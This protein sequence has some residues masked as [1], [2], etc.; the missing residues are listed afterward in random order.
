MALGLDIRWDP[1]DAPGIDDAAEAATW[2]KLRIAAPANG[3]SESVLTQVYAVHERS[4][5][6]EVFGTVLPLAEWVVRSWSHII[7]ARRADPGSL[8]PADDRY[9]WDRVHRWRYAGEGVAVP[10]LCISRLDDDLANVTWAADSD[11]PETRFERIRFLTRGALRLSVEDLRT[12]LADFVDSVIRR[13]LATAPDHDRT[14]EVRN[15]WNLVRRPDAP[16][17]G[18]QALAARLGLLW[19]DLAEEEQNRIQLLAGRPLD[20]V[21]LELLNSVRLGE[22]G[23]ALRFGDAMWRRCE[24]APVLPKKW[25][26]LRL[27]IDAERAGIPRTSEPWFKGW[28]SARI[29]R[30]LTKRSAKHRL[31][32]SDALPWQDAPQSKALPGGADSVVAWSASR[33]PVRSSA[34][35]ETSGAGRMR[36]KFGNA[37]DLY[38][39]AFGARTDQD[40]A[41]VVSPRVAGSTSV[42]N[43]FATELLAPMEAVKSRLARSREVDLFTIAEIASDLD[44]PFTCVLHQVA[45]HRLAVVRDA[46]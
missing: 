18:A 31:R 14:H 43:A 5:R 15:A 21:S 16:Q 8:A 24:D 23:M 35:E 13:L 12:C 30:R 20:P 33:T 25:R 34:R 28:E 19:W 42:A 32:S 6:D 1:L 27:A 26:E 2:A 7:E 4:V 11:S 38:F 45:N 17:H 3:A 10:D 40:Y 9:E 46:A 22:S 29:Y 37:R 41:S 39:L 36:R 44:A